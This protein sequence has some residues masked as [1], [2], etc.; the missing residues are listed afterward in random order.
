VGRASEHIAT[1]AVEYGGSQATLPLQHSLCDHCGSEFATAPQT[2][3]NKRAMIAFRKRVDGLLTGA[4]VRALRERF[5]ISQTQAARI[6]GGGPVAFSKYENDDVMQ[7]DAMDKLLRLVEAVDGAFAYLARRA[8]VAIPGAEVASAWVTRH[9]PIDSA[10]APMARARP[11]L[12]IVADVPE[13][14]WKYAS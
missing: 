12:R 2:R 6:F 9:W 5:G 14:A 8:G 11:P 3:A 1:N 4:E 10:N 7:S 13:G